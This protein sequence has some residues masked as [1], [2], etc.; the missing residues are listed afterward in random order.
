[1]NRKFSK[2]ARMVSIVMLVMLCSTALGRIQG[3]AHDIMLE[4]DYDNCYDLASGDGID[5][6]WYGLISKS[7]CEHLSHEEYTIKYYFE[8]T[9][10]NGCTWSTGNSEIIADEI[11]AAFAN[12]MEKWNNVYFYSYDSLGNVVKNKIINVIEG[13]ETDHNLAIY[14]I[15]VG[16][17]A[18]TI[19][20]GT[21]VDIEDTGDIAHKH[22]SQWK[23]NVN[24]S[25]FY[26]HDNID[27]E[28]VNIVRERNGAHEL[29]HVLGLCD[30]DS[31]CPVI[32]MHHEELLMGY[33]D[34]EDRSQD[35]TYKDIA[36]VAITRGFHTDADHKW[37]YK[38]MVDGKYKMVCSICNGVKLIDSFDGYSYGVNYFL[39]GVCYNNHA[40]SSG[41][42]MAVA[43]Y[44]NKDY[45]KCKYCRFV[46]P[47]S[48]NVL[49]NYSA[50]AIDDTHHR[51]YNNVPGLE[52]SFVEEHDLSVNGCLTCLY[53]HEHLF[54]EYLYYNNA[55]HIRSCECGATQTATHYVDRSSIISDRYAIC[56]GCNHLLDL[57]QDFAQIQ[58]SDMVLST[59]N[60]SY[61]L[62]NGI[63][64]LVEADIEAY[65]NGTLQFY[66]ADQIP[67]T[68]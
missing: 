9:S 40:L 31:Y 30:V 2:I 11:K 3:Y 16:G 23:M 19:P 24:I 50:E 37:L 64:I 27:T 44:G 61:I 41:N 13:T 10:P 14:P 4:V 34:I 35:I 68:Q 43:S 1:M 38:E 42:M 67:Q 66:P 52:Y 62:S 65:L 60:G 56:L 29:G 8:N 58:S 63:V 22:Y 54:G 53:E 48:S 15:N 5:E 51:C 26:V 7:K 47:F 57:Q 28:Y 12:S 21:G 25:Y 32:D 49:Q 39:Y 20:V 45:Y 6:I 17:I 59:M 46:A 36:G 33:G 18:Q 55:Q